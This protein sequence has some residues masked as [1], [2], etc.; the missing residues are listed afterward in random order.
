MP[1]QC[2]GGRNAGEKDKQLASEEKLGLFEE[3]IQALWLDLSPFFRPE[4]FQDWVMVEKDLLHW[5][6]AINKGGD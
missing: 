3:N 4:L 6:M 1:P 5:Q 2:P